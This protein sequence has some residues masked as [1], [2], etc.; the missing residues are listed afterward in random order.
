MKN[1]RLPI[2]YGDE[3]LLFLTMK[4]NCNEKIFFPV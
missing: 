1:R 3:E 2:S 4:T